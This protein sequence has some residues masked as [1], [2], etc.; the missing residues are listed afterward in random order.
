MKRV[1]K[2]NE[3]DEVWS[4]YGNAY[5]AI[6][7]CIENKYPCTEMS[8]WGFNKAYITPNGSVYTVNASFTR[9]D[10]ELKELVM[11]SCQARVNPG[12]DGMLLS[13][14][15]RIPIEFDDNSESYRIK[16]DSYCQIST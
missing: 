15:E 2:R 12:E 1:Y 13:C 5:T 9:F 14:S 11:V 7:Y 6:R 16:S 8:S 10:T 4:D 3:E